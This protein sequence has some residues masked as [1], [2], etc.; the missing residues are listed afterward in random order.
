MK[1]L[2]KNWLTT[3]SHYMFANK[4]F[5][6][7]V[8]DY[9]RLAQYETFCY[10]YLNNAKETSRVTEKKY[11]KEIVVSLTTFSSK[12]DNVWMTIVSLLN[13]T[14]KPNKVILYLDENEYKKEEIPK[15]LLKLEAFGLQIEFVPNYFTYK[16]YI[17]ALK[18]FPNSIIVTVDDDQIYPN[19]LL[20][21]LY[22]Q[23]KKTGNI[24]ANSWVYNSK[25]IDKYNTKE[26]LPKI[27]YKDY[28]SYL[29]GGVAGILYPPKSL[30]KDVTNFELAHKLCEMQD[31]LFITIQAIMNNS[32]IDIVHT[33]PN[34]Y[35]AMNFDLDIAFGA[36]QTIPAKK[37]IK[38]IF[39]HYKLFG[40]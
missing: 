26:K 22:N 34:D 19:D 7:E 27:F 28:Q 11:D 8:Y 20:E 33:S 37:M 16:K 21:N 18:S 1:N 24:V 2:I 13:Q 9:A 23:Y 31:D 4:T 17:P 6:K 3:V 40:Y 39:S 29:V 12:I 35:I 14:V 36:T 32:K 10:S 5:N 15:K 38:N 30:Y 25:F